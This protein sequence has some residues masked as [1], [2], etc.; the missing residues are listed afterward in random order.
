MQA[1]AACLST[2]VASPQRIC[3]TQKTAIAT[4]TGRREQAG[5]GEVL[6]DFGSMTSCISEA[7]AKVK[8]LQEEALSAD[9]FRVT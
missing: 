9:N 8:S 3:P 4:E 5:G 1:R 7:G 6:A 2:L